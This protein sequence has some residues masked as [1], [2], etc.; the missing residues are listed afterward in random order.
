MIV[1]LD[2]LV[3][4]LLVIGFIVLEAA[5][6]ALVSIWFVI[7]AAAALIA[8]IFTDSI[9]IQISVFVLVSA[10]ALLLTRP[11]LKKKLDVKATPTNTER[12]IG[13][14]ATVIIAV[15]PEQTGRVKL[16]DIDWTAESA[17]TLPVGSLCV[18]DAM[19]GNV[20]SVSPVPVSEH[21]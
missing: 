16:N 1:Y 10:L 2:S 15:S 17:Q 19:H 21:A 5:T 9:A 12:N 11:F 14:T 7:G 6:V 20:L 18:V 4:I 3:W 8:T 13:R